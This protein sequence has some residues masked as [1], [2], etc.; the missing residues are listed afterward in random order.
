MFQWITTRSSA[1]VLGTPTPLLNHLAGPFAERVA[2]LWP[3]PHAEFLAAPADRRHLVFL[4]LH[5][6]GEARLVDA[7]ALLGLKLRLALERVLTD[8]PDG[9][10]RALGKLG[11]VAW[12]GQDYDALIRL[13]RTAGGAKT[14]R[15]ADRIAPERVR[16]LDRLP[17]ALLTSKIAG[18][19]LSA[20]QAELLAETLDA[21]R[22]IRGEEG[23]QAA[24]RRWAAAGSTKGLF[25][26]AED[27]L[28]PEPPA[29]PFPGNDRLRP[30]A[31]KAAI[32]DAGARYRNCLKSQVGAAASGR[33]AFYEWTGP[34]GAVIEIW[35]DRIYGWR[36]DQARLA[37][38][39]S[40]PET[41]QAAIVEEL[42]GW[43]VH[44]GR[45]S[46]QLENALGDAHRAAFQLT[47]EREAIVDLFTDY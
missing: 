8:V 9:L 11:E 3:A 16:A 38:N 43:G 42:R 10:G 13:F 30:L 25:E 46:W 36:L 37:R 2:G 22:R 47:P 14:L 21:V 1:P 41:A 23:A 35:H 40:V 28:L 39:A 29:P 5:R 31:T 20:S 27:E 15:H 12:A 6:T 18:L 7:D 33:S 26:A 34:P 32:R 4:A 17:E 44:V 45:S 24:V 19:Q